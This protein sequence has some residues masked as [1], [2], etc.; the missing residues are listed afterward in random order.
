[1][2]LC[3]RKRST[4][5]KRQNGLTK[6]RCSVVWTSECTRA[7]KFKSV[8]ALLFQASQK[9]GFQRSPSHNLI[10]L[11]CASQQQS[12]EGGVGVGTSAPFL[13]A[14]PQKSAQSCRVRAGRTTGGVCVTWANRAAKAGSGCRSFVTFVFAA[15]CLG[16]SRPRWPTL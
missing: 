5:V 3:T 1:M 12:P 10:S 6:S 11:S 16:R 14:F 8:S 4:I 13:S 15:L 2:R 7:T 9:V